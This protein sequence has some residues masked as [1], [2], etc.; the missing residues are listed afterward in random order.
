M[1]P[2]R[3][4][5]LLGGN[6]FFNSSFKSFS[7][8][9]WVLLTPVTAALAYPVTD[10]VVATGGESIKVYPDHQT[11]G[12]YWYIPQ[13][14]EPW[15]KDN[16]YRSSLYRTANTLSFIFRGQASVDD[17]LLERVSKALKTSRAHLAP[18][19]Y[20]Y[21]KD[22]VCQNVWAGDTDLKWVFPKMIGNY[23]EIVPISLRT[24]SPSL[25]EEL[26]FH[27]AEGGGLGCTVSVGF[28]A[29]TTGYKLMM[30]ANMNTVYTRFEIAA[31]AE[32]FWWEAD[33]RAMIESLFRE[34]VVEIKTLEDVSIPQSELDKKVVVA[35][36]EII[37]RVTDMMFTPALKLPDGPMEGRGKPFSL[38][39]DYRRSAQND[40]YR[41]V[42]D[43]QR[44]QVKDTQLNI[45]MAIE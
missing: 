19:A 38:R 27:L 35:M 22:L 44:I 4:Q 11:P 29:V 42:L 3:S 28:K 43:S 16:R 45:R 15:R 21:S 23:L 36:D 7:F 26:G 25:V 6:M 17:A 30:Y 20:D 13:S 33:L 12:V 34:K 9:S 14:I 40:T 37:K 41:T 10:Q 24:S 5:C 32:Y 8:L 39:A 31:H 18:I 1:A 2:Y